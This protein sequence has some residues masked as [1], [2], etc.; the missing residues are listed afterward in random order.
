MIVTQKFFGTGLLAF[1][2]CLIPNLSRQ[3]LAADR[4]TLAAGVTV[5]SYQNRLYLNPG[6]VTQAVAVFYFT[7][8]AGLPGPL[9]NGPGMG[10]DEVTAYF[11][12]SFENSGATIIENGDVS[13]AVFSAGRSFHIYFNQAPNEN[14][15]DPLSFSTGELIA[16]YESSIGTSASSGSVTA[17]T[18][19]YFLKWSKNF[20]FRGKTYNFKRLIP[21]GFTNGAAAA[22]TKNFPVAG[23][24]VVF[25]GAGSFVAIGGP[26]S[27]LPQ[28]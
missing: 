21:N 10:P 13:T 1:A 17:V 6:P 4:P 5:L 16:T 11:T 12:A 9:L 23:F 8:I 22:G 26:L 19:T 14:W 18:Q 28:F 2:L 27:A 25:A 3:A 20:E 15:G 24:P 7:D